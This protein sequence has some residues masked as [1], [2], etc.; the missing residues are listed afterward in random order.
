MTQMMTSQGEHP[1]GNRLVDLTRAFKL[2]EERTRDS[3]RY[4]WERLMHR[5]NTKEIRVGDHMVL[6][7]GNR[8]GLTSRWDPQWV[9]T[10]ANGV[11]VYIDQTPDWSHQGGKPG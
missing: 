2:V 1:F 6:K 9:V 11:A 10:R 3:R 4:N 8:E 5:A 7:V